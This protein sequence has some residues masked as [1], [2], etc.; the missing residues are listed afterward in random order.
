RNIHHKAKRA[1]GPGPSRRTA[2]NAAGSAGLALRV[3]R[4]G[5]DGSLRGDS[6][7][8]DQ[9]VTAARFFPDQPSQQ[10]AFARWTEGTG[11]GNSSG[12]IRDG[13]TSWSPAPQ[14]AVSPGTRPTR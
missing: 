4:A 8:P 9:S 13:A 12:S 6:L 7:P 14:P 2:S 11:A 5:P 1:I 3:R 10:E